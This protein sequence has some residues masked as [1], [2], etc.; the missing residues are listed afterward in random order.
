MDFGLFAHST[1]STFA[2]PSASPSPAPSVLPVGQ[3]FNMG[4]L[5]SKF[6]WWC[7]KLLFGYTV[8]RDMCFRGIPFLSGLIKNAIEKSFTSPFVEAEETGEFAATMVDEAAQN[9]ER[10]E[11]ADAEP[12]VEPVKKSRARAKGGAYHYSSAL[13]TALGMKDGE[14]E[15]GIRKGI[16]VLG[17]RAEE[18]VESMAGSALESLMGGRKKE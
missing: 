7:M 14:V 15:L 11:E 8:V 2:S 17:D 12:V 5:E 13:E 6:F 9:L 18:V 10:A 4:F 1:S 16:D 3:A